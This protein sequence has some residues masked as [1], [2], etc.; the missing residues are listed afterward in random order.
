ME[1]GSGDFRVKGAGIGPRAVPDPRI[2]DMRSS[3]AVVCGSG[4]GGLLNESRYAH[5]AGFLGRKD[6][7]VTAS[8][9]TLSFAA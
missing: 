1:F 4:D 5:Y 9:E 2:T 7:F 6:E 8:T 3:R